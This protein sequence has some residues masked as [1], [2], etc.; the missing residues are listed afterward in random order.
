[1]GF[2]RRFIFLFF[3]G[4]LLVSGLSGQTTTDSLEIALTITHDPGKKTDLLLRLS[5][6]LK[7]NDPEKSLDYAREALTLSEETGNTNDQLTAM[8]HLAEIYCSLSDFKT[9]MD[10]AQR[11]YTTAKERN[12][13]GDEANA[14]QLIGLVYSDLGDYEKSSEY[15]YQSLEISEQTGDEEGTGKALRRI[16]SV[17]FDQKNYDKALEYYFRALNMA[18]ETGD[19]EE[20]ASGLNDIAAVYG[21]K[22]Q[23]D[24]VVQYLEEAV[25]INKELGNKRSTGINYTN[26]GMI[27]QRMK[28]YD[29]ALAYFQQALQIFNEL[30]HSV[31]IANCQVVLS[32]FYL[33]TGDSGKSIEYARKAFDTGL[34]HGLKKV[35]YD[36]AGMLH[37]AY[38]RKNDTITANEFLIRQYQ[39]KDSLEIEKSATQLSKLE[40]RYAFE[41]E[42]QQ[43]LIEQQRKDFILIIIIITLIL[44]LGIIILFLARQKIKAK[45]AELEKLNLERELEFKNKELAL[46]VMSLLKK[47][48]I[49]SEISKKLLTVKNEA[50]KEETKD[51]ITRIHKDLQKST[52]E[53]IW[54]EFELRFR[55]VHSEFYKT[56]M[57][58]FPDL[59]PSEQRLCAFLRLNMSTKE[60]SELTGQS[61]NALETARY[62]LRKKLGISNSQ[63]NLIT[64]LSQI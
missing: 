58:R 17:Y 55:Q 15:Y 29:E 19:R 45:N 21:N 4:I 22:E 5:D 48:E 10:Y 44:G 63:I 14:L 20:I 56:L 25:A 53:E 27:N 32:G 39:I 59:T 64:F 42:R 24:K 36:A 37:N 18:K 16:A 13:S 28:N 12:L 57:E 31:L 49:L 43:Q 34:K 47:N 30:N 54:E 35:M 40:I 60:I 11:S 41:K 2:L 6:E 26:L 33:E 52:D 7:N 8:L 61:L 23:Y 51:A 50:V 9:A 46:K 62:R 38:L 1:M 3:S